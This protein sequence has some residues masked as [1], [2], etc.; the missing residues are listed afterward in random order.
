MSFNDN[1]ESLDDELEQFWVVCK[2]TS[3]AAGAAGHARAGSL[4]LTIMHVRGVWL[5]PDRGRL[6][7]PWPAEHVCRA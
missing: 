7:M 6:G 2:S 5:R 4:R 3:V 1:D